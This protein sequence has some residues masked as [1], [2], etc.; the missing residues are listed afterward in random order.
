MDCGKYGSRE[1]QPDSII[2]SASDSDDL[3]AADE[4]GRQR[5]RLV[6]KTGDLR[7]RIQRIGL[8]IKQV[9]KLISSDD[10]ILTVNIGVVG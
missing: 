3:H 9:V 7:M 1:L 5:E 6:D 8:D 4:T 10:A 2:A